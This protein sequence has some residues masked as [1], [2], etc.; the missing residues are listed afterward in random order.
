MTNKQKSSRPKNYE[1]PW[2]LN[3]H[4]GQRRG[5][6]MG[7]YCVTSDYDCFGHTSDW[8]TVIHSA[9]PD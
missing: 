5:A 7:L 6:Y 1:I 9:K 3:V 8:G 4:I 2:E